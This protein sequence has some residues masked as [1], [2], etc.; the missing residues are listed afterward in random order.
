MLLPRT[1]IVRL[2]PPVGPDPSLRQCL[3]SSPCHAPGPR[4]PWMTA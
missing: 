4:S 2:V 3:W 1:G